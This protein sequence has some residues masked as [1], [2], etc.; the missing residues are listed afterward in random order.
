MRRACARVLA[1]ALPSAR[2]LAVDAKSI[3]SVQSIRALRERTGAP[4][5][6]VKRA[7]DDAGGD[8][9]RAFDALRAKGLAAAAKKA[10][11]TSAE[12]AAG[13][14]RAGRVVV[15]AE[16]NSET[17]FVSR[18]AAFVEL[19][20]EVTVSLGEAVTRDEAFAREH[21][22]AADGG[23][24][25]VRDERLAETKTRDGR[26]LSDAARDV[27]VSVRENVRVRRAFAHAAMDGEVV[28]TY[29]HGALAPGVGKQASFVVAK[30]VSEDFANKIAMHVVAS[31]PLYLRS[32]CV[33]KEAY[34]REMAVFR[35]QTENAGKPANIVE[36]ILLGRMNKYYEE[37][38][39]ENQKFIL[40]DSTTVGK[41]VKAEGGELIAFARVKV[42][43]GIEVEHKDFAAEVAEA[44]RT[45]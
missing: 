38:C 34:D 37:V 8:V 27:A 25:A 6:D 20:R 14:A 17:D 40:D 3:A 10:G 12:G 21:E 18:G 13:V 39:L 26:T 24:R 22:T 33:P 4:V 1:S 32:D 44:V 11:R 16:V 42:G 43:E 28:G 7:L 19:V 45:T 30:G 23:A 5:V 35:A 31:A 36:K 2:S 41:A 15:A 29:A 9:E